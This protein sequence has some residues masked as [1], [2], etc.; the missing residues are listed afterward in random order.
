MRSI[1]IVPIQVNRQLALERRESVGNE[2]QPARALGLDRP[3][4]TLNYRQVKWFSEIMRAIL[5]GSGTRK[6]AVG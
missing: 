5:A 6:G 4:G 1:P 3:N 2:N